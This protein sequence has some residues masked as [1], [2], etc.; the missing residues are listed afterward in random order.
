M[1]WTAI[2]DR[3]LAIWITVFTLLALRLC[4]MTFA[5]AEAR[6]LETALPGVTDVL[7][8]GENCRNAHITTRPHNRKV[9]YHA[10]SKTWLIFH[11]TGHWIDRLGN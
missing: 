4:S 3:R 10:R 8:D 6:S 1:N 9:V 2:A 5:E 7:V 11:G